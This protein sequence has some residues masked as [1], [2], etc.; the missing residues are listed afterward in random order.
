MTL[1]DERA[2]DRLRMHL[3]GI[4]EWPGPHVPDPAALAAGEASIR[5]YWGDRY[6]PRCCC[7]TPAPT[8]PDGRCERCF[9]RLEVKR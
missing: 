5:E 4:E 9:G 7:V 6:R 1:D 2:R 8:L 3:K